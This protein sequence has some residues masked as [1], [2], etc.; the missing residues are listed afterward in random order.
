M[1][2]SDIIPDQEF[3]KEL[4]QLA[5]PVTLQCLL[6]S[7]FGVIDQVMTGQLGSVSIA[8]IGLAGKFISLL[9]VM[10]QAV[11]YTH[12]TLPTICSV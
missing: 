11:S 1:K 2:H 4:L 3:R 7:A 12:L 9:T 5:L 8:G 10:V 6:H